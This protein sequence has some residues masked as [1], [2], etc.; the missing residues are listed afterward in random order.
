MRHSMRLFKILMHFLK[1]YVQKGL[2]T[3]KTLA[4]R[5]IFCGQFLSKTNT[6]YVQKGLKT[7]KTLAH[8]KIVYDQ[9]VSKTN[10]G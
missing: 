3:S 7:S 4:N 1:I 8:R 9:F 6:I 5:K 10:T 2:K